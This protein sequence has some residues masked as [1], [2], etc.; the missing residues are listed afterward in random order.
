MKKIQFILTISALLLTITPA[1]AG[2]HASAPIEK[3]PAKAEAVAPLQ[4]PSTAAAMADGEVRKVDKENKKM[5]IRHGEI[6]N[7]DMPPMSMV[8]QVRDPAL[9][10]KIKPGDKIRFSAEK[11]EGAFVVTAIE[12]KN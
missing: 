12:P 3:D 1:F 6:K 2:S 10:D 5:T 7:L 4:T 11:S 9:L 8:F